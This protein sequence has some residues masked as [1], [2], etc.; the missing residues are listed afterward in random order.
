MNLAVE[1]QTWYALICLTLWIE[2]YFS[3]Q[4]VKSCI[5]PLW[6]L[7]L[8]KGPP[9]HCGNCTS[10]KDHLLYSL[11]FSGIDWIWSSAL[12]ARTVAT[13]AHL[14]TTLLVHRIADF[15]N[16]PV[17]S[18]PIDSSWLITDK[19]FA[20]SQNLWLAQ[21]SGGWPKK[22][23]SPSSLCEISTNGGQNDSPRQFEYIMWEHFAFFP[24][25]F[26]KRFPKCTS[27]HLS[28]FLKSQGKEFQK[29]EAKALLVFF[30]Y[31]SQNWS[32]IVA[33]SISCCCKGA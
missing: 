2:K 12:T 8:H 3:N 14:C 7:C 6:H 20:A 27:S 19:E 9:I 17:G 18:I 11:C 26:C 24:P 33:F 28:S 15:C 21:I 5:L 32:N 1:S 13:S 25:I 23:M 30:C 4:V 22:F 16:V 29:W 10:I 31:P